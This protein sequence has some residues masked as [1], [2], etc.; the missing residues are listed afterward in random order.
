M[1]T[2]QFILY[3]VKSYKLLYTSFINKRGF[4]L[5][6]LELSRIAS[7]FNG[8]GPF[9]LD[10]CQK[11]KEKVSKRSPPLTSPYFNVIYMYT[12]K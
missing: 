10:D 1:V 6:V 12:Y 9:K 8:N 7:C 5:Q 2:K 4:P 11:K 3:K